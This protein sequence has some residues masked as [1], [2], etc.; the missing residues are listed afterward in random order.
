MRT[1]M[2]VLLMCWAVM[3]VHAQEAVQVGR[4]LSVVPVPTAVQQEPLRVIIDVR[5]PRT[6]Q[7]VG[8]AFAH[9][10]YPSGYGLVGPPRAL[11]ETGILFTRP[12]PEVHRALGPMSLQTALETL[13]GSAWRLVLDPVYREVSFRLDP[14]L[15]AF[16]AGDVV[17]MK[18]LHALDSGLVD[19]DEPVLD[20]RP[21]SP[22][23]EAATLGILGPVRPGQSLERLVRT[24]WTD[25]SLLHKGMVA[26][27][28]HNPHAFQPIGGE[29]NLFQLRTEV[30]LEVPDATSVASIPLV[31]ANRILAEHRARWEASRAPEENPQP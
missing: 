8:E 19:A 23:V 13:A 6:V 30:L 5:F 15:M 18:A 11:P 20:R 2:G 22:E 9:L 25:R 26:L 28:Q 12:L 21:P 17:P 7:T 27:W 14:D 31:E 29:P 10:L 3:P 4:Y 16:Y 24:V 1:R